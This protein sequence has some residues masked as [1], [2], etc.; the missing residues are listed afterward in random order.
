MQELAGKKVAVFGLGGM[1]LRHLEA[2]T[3]AGATIVGGVDIRPETKEKLSTLYPEARWYSSPGELL[4]NERPDILSV[5]TNGPSHAQQVIAV[6]EARVPVIMCE[7]PMA[8]NMRDAQ[9]MIDAA[10]ASGS[11]LYMNFTLRAFPT[12]Q[13]IIALAESGAVGRIRNISVYIGGGRG[14]G[15]VGSHYVDMM[16]CILK[17]EPVS[18]AGSIDKTGTP[19]VRGAQFKDP[20]GVATYLFANGARGYLEMSEDFTLPPYM[21]MTGEEGRIGM[22]IAQNKLLVERRSENNWHSEVVPV[23]TPTSLVEGTKDM[24]IDATNGGTIASTGEDG[25]RALGMILGI[26]AS[27]QIDGASVALPL[28]ESLADLNVPMT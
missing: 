5:V 16:R 20:G 9:N 6:A 25:A 3:L 1:G 13:K 7:K 4:S 18:V 22:D 14:L 2:Y 8:T 19:N 23:D 11:R 26:H 27:A 12:F 24:L 10:N 17:S 21:L 28:S 15:C